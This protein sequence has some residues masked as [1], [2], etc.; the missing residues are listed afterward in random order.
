MPCGRGVKNR[1]PPRRGVPAR[2]MLRPARVGAVGRIS[3]CIRSPT[4]AVPTTFTIAPRSISPPCATP[5]GTVGIGGCSTPP[6]GPAGAVGSGPAPAPRPDW[7]TSV[8]FVPESGQG[9]ADPGRRAQ[10][11][12]PRLGGREPHRP[13][14]AGGVDGGTCSAHAGRLNSRMALGLPHGQVSVR[15]AGRSPS[16]PDRRRTSRRGVSRRLVLGHVFHV[17]PHRLA[18]GH[19]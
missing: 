5:S 15:K 8:G 12:D 16:P 13:R 9:L 10:R 3:S 14:S 7:I 6:E 17:R 18:G 1:D 11:S 19:L 4:P 2:R